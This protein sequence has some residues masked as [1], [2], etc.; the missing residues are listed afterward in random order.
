MIIKSRMQS[1]VFELWLLM[2]LSFYEIVIGPK[3]ES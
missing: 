3:D 1:I 2:N